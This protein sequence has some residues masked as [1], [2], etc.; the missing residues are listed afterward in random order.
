MGVHDGGDGVVVDMAGALCDVFDC[1][2]G[3]FLGFVGEHGA[4]GAVADDA[5]VGQFGAVLFVDDEAAFVVEVEVE[6]FEAETRGVGA[7]ADGDED[8]VC[9]ELDDGG[10]LVSR[11][12]E[13]ED[14]RIWNVWMGSGLQSLACRLWQLRLRA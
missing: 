12:K 11:G 6:V 14:V 10:G 5:D 2:D 1:G 13:G 8:D 3:F 7:A 4:E 9:F